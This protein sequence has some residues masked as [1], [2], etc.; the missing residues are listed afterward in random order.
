MLGGLL[1]TLSMVFVGAI[2]ATSITQWSGKS[3]LWFA[4]FGAKQYGEEAVD[5]LFLGIPFILGVLI[6]LIG[7]LILGYEY[8]KSFKK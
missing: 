2:Y 8:Y 3:K 5:T 1:V 7:L 4:I 6:T